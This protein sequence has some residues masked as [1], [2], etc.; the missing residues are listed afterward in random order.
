MAFE[1]KD[2]YMSYVKRGDQRGLFNVARSDEVSDVE[3]YYAFYNETGSYVF[4]QI[5]TSGTL[6]VKVYKYYARGSKRE[7]LDL[8]TDWA[9]R[10]SLSYVEYHALFNQSD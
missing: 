3:R 1:L 8:T 5:T 4:Q 2:F 7:V 9:N 10:A 6:G